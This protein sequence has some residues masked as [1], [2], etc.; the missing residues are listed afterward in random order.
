MLSLLNLLQGVNYI[1]LQ[2]VTSNSCIM[3]TTVSACRCNW[4]FQGDNWAIC[5]SMD[6]LT[7][8]LEFLAKVNGNQLDN[9]KFTYRKGK[10][11]YTYLP[12]HQYK[13]LQNLIYYYQSHVPKPLLGNLIETHI[14]YLRF[15]VK[16]PRTFV[17]AKMELR[18]ARTAT[19]LKTTDAIL[20]GFH[21]TVGFMVPSPSTNEPLRRKVRFR[22]FVSFIVKL[23]FLYG[24]V[25]AVAVANLYL[26]QKKEKKYISLF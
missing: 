22:R 4:K 17:M 10:Q 12:Q 14:K 15:D 9:R 5:L 23:F 21:G 11:N 1:M 16:R 26:S 3:D 13:Q 24:K 7:Y 18:L 6:R 19:I 25:L 8:F 20:C 2:T